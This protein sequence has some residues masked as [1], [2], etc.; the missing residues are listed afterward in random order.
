MLSRRAFLT[1]LGITALAVPLL[2][3]CGGGTAAGTASAST[4]STSAAL[5]SSS[6]TSAPATATTSSAATTAS[7]SAVTTSAASATSSAATSATTSASAATST[8]AATSASTA[9][10]AAPSGAA[11]PLSI[12]FD[13]GG[14]G[15]FAYEDV[16]AAFNKKYPGINATATQVSDYKNKRLT[17]IASNTLQ[18]AWVWLMYGWE[19]PE[20]AQKNLLRPLDS[21]IATDKVNMQDFWPIVLTDST[22]NG[23][24]YGMT[25][26]PA[27]VILWQ[28]TDLAKGAGLDTSKPPAS[29][30]D[31][32]TA[33][34][35]L[36]QRSGT[37]F[38]QIGND[39]TSTPYTTWSAFWM[40]ANGLSVISDDGKKA[41]FN[42]APAQDALNYVI[43]TMDQVYGGPTALADWRKAEKF[44]FA[45]MAEG[46]AGL[47]TNGNW[48]AWDIGQQKSPIPFTIA[49]IPG[50][51]NDAGK[52]YIPQLG[53]LNSIPMP[54]TD[55]DS[56]WTYANY[57]ASKEG[58]IIM[59]QRA[60]DVPG[61][62]AAAEDPASIKAHYGRAQ[63][64]DLFKAANAL[65]YVR[66]PAYDAVNK[67]LGT[68]S[69]D[70]LNKKTDVATALA[71]AQQQVQAALDAYWSGK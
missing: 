55:P 8:S 61:N 9:A 16:T 33:T 17:A 2:Q 53:T 56:S 54:A 1:S 46:K 20:F 18:G 23:K 44:K 43:K 63:V 4:G 67:A 29:W 47:E 58:Q 10:A 70:T 32:L 71:T 69:S 19:L 40:A 48:I 59:Q 15:M 25:N 39:P 7:S 27:V 13:Y 65:V 30:D 41:T 64:L 6:A 38:T 31:L 51:S 62:I 45:A 3:A 36:T 60:E 28:N 37:T 24:N 14:G 68:L 22:Y 26:H 34:Q 50:G 49:G 52:Q 57:F 66:T 11:K 21:Y 12:W 42:G 5:A 35:K